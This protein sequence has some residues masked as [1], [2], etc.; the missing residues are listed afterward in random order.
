[1]PDLQSAVRQIVIEGSIRE[2]RLMLDMLA[3]IMNEPGPLAAAARASSVR[4]ILE[5]AEEMKEVTG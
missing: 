1:M 5:A 4:T 2:I 3:T